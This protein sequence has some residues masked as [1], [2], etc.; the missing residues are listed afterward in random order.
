[1]CFIYFLFKQFYFECSITTNDWQKTI[2]FRN[3]DCDILNKIIT[4]YVPIWKVKTFYRS[5]EDA[6]CQNYQTEMINNFRKISMSN[7][8][9]LTRLLLRDLHTVMWN[10]CRFH[11]ICIRE[12]IDE[13][14]TY[15]NNKVQR[16]FKT[17]QIIYNRVLNRVLFWNSNRL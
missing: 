12:C 6:S 3:H 17:I 4:F 15:M 7:C 5:L 8:L 9:H 14:C 11:C 16:K 1:M 2:K 10:Y 13:Y